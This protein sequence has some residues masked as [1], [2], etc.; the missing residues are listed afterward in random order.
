MSTLYLTEQG[1]RI[2]LKGQRLILKRDEELLM[3]IPLRKISRLFLFGNIQ[4]TTPALHALLEEEV[5]VSF[6]SARGRFKGSLG[7]AMSRNIPLRVA[8][9]ESW[10][11][12]G[13]RLQI[14]QRLIEAKLRNMVLFLRRYQYNYPEVDFSLSIKTIQDGMSQL[15]ATTKTDSILGIEGY[16]SR[17]YFKCFAVMCRGSLQFPGRQMHPSP[18]PINALLSLGYTLV[19]SEI[20]AVLEAMSIDPYL[21]YLHGIRYGRKSLALDLLEE[22]RQAI[23]DPMTLRIINLRIFTEDDFVETP[24][25]VRLTSPAF[26]T[27]LREYEKRMEEARVKV[28][29]QKLNWR[30][31]IQK[32]IG[33]LVICIQEREIYCPH[34]LK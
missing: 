16:C 8:Q 14:A 32:Q 7:G 11:D 2:S 24:K 10:S 18:D 27:Y 1:T 31:V 15:T 30:S 23:V 28:Q 34:N 5:D 17:E 19:A 20:S 12:Q 3:D 13:Y 6:F 33:K 26:K 25:G 21:G 22:F 29:D 9:Y 4:L